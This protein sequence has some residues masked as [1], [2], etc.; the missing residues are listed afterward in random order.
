[1]TTTKIS[2][3]V[4]PINDGWDANIHI[5]INEKLITQMVTHSTIEVWAAH[6]NKATEELARLRQHGSKAPSKS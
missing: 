5:T 3:Q 2:I 6:L 4:E 1:M